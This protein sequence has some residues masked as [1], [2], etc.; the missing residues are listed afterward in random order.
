MS[1]IDIFAAFPL[2]LSLYVCSDHSPLLPL[3]PITHHPPLSAPAPARA[4][5]AVAASAGGAAEAEAEAD[6]DFFPEVD[7]AA[8]PG[9]AAAAPTAPAAGAAGGAKAAR[10][11]TEEPS[12]GLGSSQSQAQRAPSLALKTSA[13]A[14]LNSSNA[15]SPCP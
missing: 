10:Q 3:Q 12:L 8:F 9:L 13:S 2:S 4:R 14:V 5:S 11:S 7:L 6:T 15:V 1:F